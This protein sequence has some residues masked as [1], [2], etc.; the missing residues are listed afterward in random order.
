MQ[1]WQITVLNETYLSLGKTKEEAEALA[2]YYE[3]KYDMAIQ[4]TEILQETKEE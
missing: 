2:N 1:F 4:F 3:G